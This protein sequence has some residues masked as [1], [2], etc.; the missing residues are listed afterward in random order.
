[1][2]ITTWLYI[3]LIT[4]LTGHNKL[5]IKTVGGSQQLRI[6]INPMKLYYLHTHL[7]KWNTFKKCPFHQRQRTN[8]DKLCSLYGTK[9][10][11]LFCRKRFPLRWTKTR[12]YWYFFWCSHQLFCS[13]KYMNVLH[14]LASLKYVYFKILVHEHLGRNS[15]KIHQC[16]FRLRKRC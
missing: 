16:A 15:N 9:S 14:L 7:E 10:T 2:S 11:K 3:Y 13:K 1:M 4:W 6:L 8:F 5:F 12:K